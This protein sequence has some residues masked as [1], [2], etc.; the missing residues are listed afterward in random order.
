MT[1]TLSFRDRLRKG[2]TV[3]KWDLRNCS[4]ALLIFAILSSVF[5]AIV[6]TLS[7]T[8]G[9]ADATEEYTQ[10][11]DFEK[12]KGAVMAFQLI[13]TYGIF[14]LNA[15][16]TIIYTIRIYSYLHNKRKADMYGALPIGRR[17]FFIAKTV[18]A[19]LLSVVPTLFFFGV[20][21]VISLCLGQPLLLE[22]AGVY[23]Q[24]LVGAIASISFYSLLSI[25]CGTTVNAV[26][27]FVA[28]NFAYPIAALFIKGTVRSFFY[29]MPTNL[30]NNSFIM[31]A[32]N[33]LAAYE[34]SN[35][36]YWLIFTA[37]CLALAIWLVKKRPAECAQNTFAYYLPA[38][39]VKLL[40]AFIIGMFLGT[41]FGGLNV[42]GF[43]LIGFIFGFTLGSVPA[44]LIAHIIFY[45]GLNRFPRTLIA[46]G[47]MSATVFAAM[48]FCFFDF[49]GYTAFVP[50]AQN[51]KSAGVVELG[52]CYYTGKTSVWNIAQMA[53]D[54]YTDAENIKRVQDYHKSV[55][56]NYRIGDDNRFT[57]VWENMFLSGITSELFS[58]DSY[59]VAYKLNNGHT[60][61]RYYSE[62]ESL[63]GSYSSFVDCDGVNEI[64]AS[65]TYYRNYSA[66]LN[67]RTDEI[68]SIAVSSKSYNDYGSSAYSEGIH[69]E[70]VEGK[71][72]A[73]Q[74]AADRR[75]VMEAYRRD[76]D[77]LDGKM[78]GYIEEKTT[79]P[80][81]SDD[82]DLYLHIRY[83][84]TDV[85]TGSVLMN[86][87]GSIITQYDKDTDTGVISP[88]CTE[89]IQALQDVGVLDKGGKID[90]NSA[91]YFKAKKIYER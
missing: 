61:I 25:C 19:Y 72:S 16:F 41:V 47:A 2:F 21:A 30:Y 78:S 35:I 11:V 79:N 75:K 82:N 85:D 50:V 49:L 57:R 8:F 9:I 24:L 55:V 74:A 39:L 67:A 83:T 5:A 45:R 87:F 32:L 38:Y 69:I 63:F 52:N 29:G 26:L 88:E 28:V 71:V 56:A 37:A 51:V 23:V 40:V 60:V 31:K 53:A 58:D 84:L 70:E 15:V 77:R 17:T 3:F 89:T 43:P 65:D 4:G 6:L 20:I 7:L 91:Y 46:F 34:G 36:I 86:L 27:A 12:L 44:Y 48:A 10:A 18:S 59:V 22:T 80:S 1:P 13:T 54:D 14:Y 62:R 42:F 66:L 33:P 68:N 64:I 81:H 90:Q 76:Y 73:A